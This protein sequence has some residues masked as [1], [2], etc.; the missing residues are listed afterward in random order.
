MQ[1]VEERVCD[2]PVL[3]LLR[4]GFV[5]IWSAEVAWPG[6]SVATDEAAMT[7]CGTSGPA[8]VG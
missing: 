6:K 2:Q 4:A 1:A 8:W 5:V 3:K 7:I